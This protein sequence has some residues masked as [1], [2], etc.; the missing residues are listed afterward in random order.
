[1]R[2]TKS[3]LALTSLSLLL[4]SSALVPSQAQADDGKI[5]LKTS[6]KGQTTYE[7]NTDLDTLNASSQDSELLEAKATL[8]GDLNEDF[9]FYTQA[10]LVKNYGSGG[11]IDSD[12]GEALGRDD[13]AELRQYW[14]EYS[15]LSKYLPFS[16]RA[17]RQ[18]FR[19]DRSLW[20]NRDFDAV[21][22]IYNATLFKGFLAA[23][24]NMVEYRSSGDSFNEQ[25]QGIF[26]VLGQTSWQW[27][28]DNFFEARFAYQNDHSG[29][30]AVGYLLTPGDRDEEDSDLL[31]IGGRTAGKI[32]CESCALPAPISYRADAIVL[33][34]KQKSEATTSAANGLR[35]V[36]GHSDQDVNAWAVDLGV[37]VPVK[38]GSTTPVLTLGYA[39]GSGDKNTSDNNDHAFRQT[40][41]DGNTSYMNG[42]SSS[43]YNYG[44][45]L[46]P[47]LSNIHIITAGFA[48]PVSNA[49]D[50]SAQYHYYRLAQNA[51]SLTTSGITA[52]LNGTDK[53]LGQGLDVMVNVD[54]SK[55]LNIKRPGFD[56][57]GLKT[58][59]GAF[60][61]G[62]AYGTAKGETA[63]RGQLDL[64]FS[65]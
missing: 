20:W 36:S 2:K 35:S 38:I 24:Q 53:Y 13:Y 60:K 42:A 28:K 11:S 51:T 33:T 14:I 12:T 31:W 22:L 1:M 17:G 43:S 56:R 55:E 62:D 54:V 18:R 63:L 58:T 61:A 34:G 8:Y 64:R 10:R 47:D 25:D 48:V 26:R 27:T 65:F 49:S 59:L 23:G 41:L 16:V 30:N 39:Y 46:R 15:G 37:D 21:S 44:S 19:E 29:Q 6:I 32:D 3:C 40:G 7:D 4:L 45:V 57:I 5:R 52:P 50:V 9:S